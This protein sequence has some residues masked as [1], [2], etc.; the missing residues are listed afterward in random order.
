MIEEGKR[1]RPIE[2]EMK[3][4]SVLFV[5]MHNLKREKGFLL[6]WLPKDRRLNEYL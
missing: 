4:S 3:T 6:A 1:G 2:R 5:L